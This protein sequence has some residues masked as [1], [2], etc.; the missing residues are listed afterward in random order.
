MTQR[1]V[2]IKKYVECIIDVKEGIT[3][4]ETELNYVACYDDEEV[5]DHITTDSL[6]KIL[7]EQYNIIE[8]SSQIDPHTLKSIYITKSASLPRYKLREIKEKYNI[9][10]VRDKEKADTVVVSS[11]EVKHIFKRQWS[12]YYYPK[13]D[14][15]N[16]LNKVND[17]KPKLDSLF[18]SER[19]DWIKKSLVTI[20]NLPDDIIFL[21]LDYTQVNIFRKI[22]T[23]VS[24]FIV[25][26]HS[27]ESISSSDYIQFTSN[28]DKKV[29]TDS[30]LQSILGSSTLEHKDYL[31]IN[32]LLNNNDRSNVE[33]GLTMMANCN[34][35]TSKHYLMLLLNDHYNKYYSWPY[36]KSVSFKSLLIYLTFNRYKTFTYDEILT[37]A[38]DLNALDEELKE[39]IVKRF[40]NESEAL[41]KKY[42]WIKIGEIIVKK[43]EEKIDDKL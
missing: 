4:V 42:S 2:G 7:F 32:D 6:Q 25:H 3:V 33:V 43:P 23:K 27:L 29:I 5:Y 16:F 35:S 17:T 14:M 36:C 18:I 31:F 9:N 34:F 21:K 1:T 26:T 20:N 37:A 39:I 38:S 12:N 28:Q 30:S 8:D 13:Q 15:I 19:S 41:L 10:V 40:L 22:F 24:R 11:N